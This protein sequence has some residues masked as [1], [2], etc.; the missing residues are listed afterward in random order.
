MRP[1]TTF[2]S[3]SPTDRPRPSTRCDGALLLG[4]RVAAGALRA[5][6]ESRNERAHL[7]LLDGREVFLAGRGAMPSASKREAAAPFGLQVRNVPP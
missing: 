3:P 6:A 1:S 4:A 7:T 2:R 5:A